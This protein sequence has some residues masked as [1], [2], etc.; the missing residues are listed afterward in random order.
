MEV[1][2]TAQ[3]LWLSTLIFGLAG[4]LLLL[5]LLFVFH[6]AAFQR[7]GW[8]LAIASGVSWGV[9]AT[10]AIFV[11]WDLY[12]QYIFPAWA[13]RWAPLDALLYTAIGLGMWWLAC[14]LPGSPVFWFVL[15]GGLEGIVEHV[16]GVYGQHILEKVPMLQGAPVALVILFS[17][18]EYV[19]YWSIVAWLGFAL[20]RLGQWLVP[21]LR[22]G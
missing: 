22:S 9:M 16:L 5:P 2:L 17:F 1:K 15:L 8:S 20:L 19:L 4:L 14:R 6:P 13:H 10:I 11:F 18:F 7:A 12:Y 21:S 3:D